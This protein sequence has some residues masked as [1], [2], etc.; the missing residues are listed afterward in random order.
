[1]HQPAL[2]G[3]LG[4]EH[5]GLGCF[6][7]PVIKC[8]KMMQLWTKRSET[9]QLPRRTLPVFLSLA[10]FLGAEQ[11]MREPEGGQEGTFPS[12]FF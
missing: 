8:E 12:F 5:L 3:N 7:S 4:P 11:D 2:S 10:S 6:V 1:M 9:H